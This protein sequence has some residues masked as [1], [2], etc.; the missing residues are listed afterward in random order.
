MTITALVPLFWPVMIAQAAAGLADAIFPPAVAAISLGIFG[1]A[2][3]SRRIG[4]NEAFNHLGNAVTAIVAG[5]A[6]Y[7]IAPAAVLWVVVVLALASAVA[8]YTIDRNSIDHELARGADDGNASD[9]PKRFTRLLESRPLLLFTAAITLFHFANAAMLPLLGKKLSQGH[10]EASSLFLAACILTA[11]VA[12]VPMALLVGH[13]ADAWGRKPLFLAGFAVLP[14]RGLLYLVTQ[15]PY[16]LVSIQ[17]PD[18][19]GAGIFGALFF[20]VVADL[21]RGT[22]HYNLALG[23]TG[24]CWG[25]GAALSSGV[26]GLLVDAAGYSA[27][28]LFFAG[29]ALAALLTFWFGVPETRNWRRRVPAGSG[30]VSSSATAD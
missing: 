19:I 8:A 2:V 11:Q 29:C 23:V 21:T 4:R 10:Q 14:V 22:G 30:A 20:V 5:F 17:E 18:G 15:N 7:S 27:A 25:L 12:M 3:F 13:K 9:E 28:F 16:L 24:A 6:G 1:R 26:A